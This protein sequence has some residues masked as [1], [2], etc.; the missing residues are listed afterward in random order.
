MGNIVDSS[1]FLAS[2]KT[3][4]G[5]KACSI[6]MLMLLNSLRKY[7]VIRIVSSIYIYSGD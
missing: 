3:S 2:N 5:I 6:Y 7:T 1:L 4:G